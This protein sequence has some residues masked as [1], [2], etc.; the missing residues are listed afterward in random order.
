MRKDGG[1]KTY[2]HDNRRY[3]DLINGVGCH[4]RQ[5]V[6]ETDLQE[7]DVTAK[8]KSRDILRKVAFGTSFV[9]VGILF[10]MLGKNLGK[11][12]IVCMTC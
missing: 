2:F 11:H 9:I 6:K 3:A 5:I 10:Y 4:G 8:D 7:E 1:W 12:R